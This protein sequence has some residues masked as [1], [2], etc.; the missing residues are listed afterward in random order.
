[1]SFCILE[2]QTRDL[3]RNRRINCQYL[4]PRC[5][6]TLLPRHPTAFRSRTEAGNHF[7]LALGVSVQLTQPKQGLSCVGC[8]GQPKATNT[9]KLCRTLLDMA[10][11]VSAGQKFFLC[12]NEV[13]CQQLTIEAFSLII[14]NIKDTNIILVPMTFFFFFSVTKVPAGVA[15]YLATE[16]ET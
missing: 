5:C 11:W 9:S 7:L 13:L 6:Y 14:A 2:S 3:K 16:V 4:T 8:S 12:T 10:H 1:M 15:S